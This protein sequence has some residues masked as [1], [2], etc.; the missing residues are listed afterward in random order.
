MGSTFGGL[1]DS[2][3]YNE[4][5]FDSFS[6]VTPFN[7]TSSALDWPLYTIG[8]P[9]NNVAGLK[10]IEAQI[11]FTY[12]TIN[13]TNNTF[14][15]Y[16]AYSVPVSL[17]TGTITKINLVSCTLA[18]NQFSFTAGMVGGIIVYS[19]A[20]FSG[21]NGSYTI[22]AFTNSLTVTVVPALVIGT[23]D[24]GGTFTFTGTPVTTLSLSLPVG[25]YSIPATCTSAS[26]TSAV[27]STNILYQL[28]KVLNANTTTG[29][30]YSATYAP[31]N[32]LISIVNTAS[33]TMPVASF[34]FVFDNDP[35]G[36]G[37]TNIRKFIGFNNGLSA[38][39][40][41]VPFPT[42][43]STL[44]SPNIANVTGANY[45]YLNSVS[46]GSAIKL[47]L[48]A[49]YGS[50]AQLAA[51]GPQIA[52]IPVLAQP[53]GVTFWTDPDPI[54]YFDVD[55]INNIAQIDFYCTLGT[56]PT[57]IAFNGGNFSLKLGMLTNESTHNDYLGGGK[58]NDRAVQRTWPT[59][60]SRINPY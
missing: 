16:E 40:T 43:T 28:V 42:S 12:Y 5:E 3:R 36:F 37:W 7:G 50:G 24:T 4:F 47:F 19:G 46:L 23:T 20:Q 17:G 29:G 14:K 6:A 1:S 41:A 10:I 39:S 11:P 60:T 35:A 2:L 57:P 34:R 48:P 44:T 25:N 21:N 51:D 52:K 45:M 27:N 26:S 15:V 53:G 38:T 22:T 54:K 49:S 8:K 31:G 13:S 58:Q 56:N 9:L 33:T 30:T 59:G 55:N 18:T 32:G